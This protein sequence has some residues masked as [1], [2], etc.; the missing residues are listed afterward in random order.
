MRI[1]LVVDDEMM[2]LLMMRRSQKHSDVRLAP[3]ASIV[4]L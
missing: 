4:L 3:N 1:N 2:L